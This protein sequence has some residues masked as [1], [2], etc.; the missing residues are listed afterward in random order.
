[1]AVSNK[2]LD[3]FNDLT[4]FNNSKGCLAPVNRM[5]SNLYILLN[6]VKP[7]AFNIAALMA[8]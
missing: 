1:M 6:D 4:E 2:S 8:A 3:A 5:V 7:E